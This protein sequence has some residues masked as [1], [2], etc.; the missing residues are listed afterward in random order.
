MYPIHS[1]RYNEYVSDIKHKR[2]ENGSCQIVVINSERC[3][4]TCIHACMHG[5]VC[6][7]TCMCTCAYMYACMLY[8]DLFSC[9]GGLFKQYPKFWSL[10][11]EYSTKYPDAIK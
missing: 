2:F 9:V 4:V 11:E 8:V 5:C 7:F 1:I 6:V 3:L 10:Y